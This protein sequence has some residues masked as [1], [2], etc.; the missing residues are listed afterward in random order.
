MKQKQF[1]IRSSASGQIMGVKGLGKTGLTYCQNWLKEQIYNRKKEFTNKYVQKGLIMEDN[2]LDF[3]ADQLGFGM[4]LKNETYFEND[5]ITGTPDIVL[6]DLIIDVKNSW[7]VFT[8]PLFESEISLNHDYYFQAQCYMD[9]CNIDKYKLIYVISDTPRHLI[10]AEAKRYM[11]QSGI[12]ELD[13]E[14]FEDFHKKMTYSDVSAN[15]KIKVFEIGRDKDIID[16]IYSRVQEC[17]DYIDGLKTL[18]EL[19]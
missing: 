11:W 3:V 4:L 10:I 13:N 17:R 15:L 12:E 2:S 19:N 18:Y 1:K 5:Y 14:L 7:D 8:F 16:K 9:I 6:K